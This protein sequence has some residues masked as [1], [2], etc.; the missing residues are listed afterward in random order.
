LGAPETVQVRIRDTGIGIP[1]EEVEKV[2]QPFYQVDR[3]LNR[4]FE[5]AG[6]GLTLAKRYLELHG[7]SIQLSSEVGTGTVVVAAL[8]RPAAAVS[9]PRL[10]PT[11]L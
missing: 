3:R 7:G 10:E 11:T 1:P 9:L 6:I 5:G 4:A 8:P 2:F